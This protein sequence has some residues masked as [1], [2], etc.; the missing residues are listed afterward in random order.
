VVVVAV[1]LA[2]CGHAD[3][4]RPGEIEPTVIHCAV[5]GGMVETGLWK[6]VSARFEA[7]TRHHVELT[8]TGSKPAVTE[9]F[10]HGGI[11]LIVVHASDAMMNLVAD[12]LAVDP[13]PWVRNDLVLVGPS[14]DPAGARGSDALVAIQRIAATHQ[15]LLVH[16]TM[17][18]DTVLHELT[19]QT[20]VDLSASSVLFTGE[21]QRQALARA[22]ELHAYTFVARIP[23]IEGKLEQPGMELLV[24]GDA[25]LRRPFLVET[26]VHA[27]AAAKQLAAFLRSP[28]TQAWLATWGKGKFDDQPLFF[29]V[30][31]P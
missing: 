8:M 15:K 10:R 17:G 18:A 24:K 6:A 20:P 27:S 23:M 1:A 7:A 16:E 30:T 29:P 5:I 4:T 31:V 21:D 14:D 26:S 13:E 9:A 2:A 3:L 22:A 12:G 19:D 28:E 11:D 25:R